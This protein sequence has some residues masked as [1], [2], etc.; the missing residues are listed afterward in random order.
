MTELFAVRKFVA[1]YRAVAGLV[2]EETARRFGLLF[3]SEELE[4]ALS[5]G[6][7]EDDS[8]YIADSQDEG[9]GEARRRIREADASLEVLRARSVAE[10]L[11][12]HGLDFSRGEYL[13]VPQASGRAFLEGRDIF[14]LSVY[15]DSHWKVALQPAPGELE[16]EAERERLAEAEAEAEERVMARLSEAVM[17]EAGRL[18]ACEE[19]LARFDLARACAILV[20][21]LGLVRPCFAGRG[22]ALYSVRGGRHLPCERSCRALGSE[23]RPLDLGLE[24]N[25]AVIFGSNMGGKT[26]ALMSILYFQILAQLGLFVPAEAFETRPYRFIQ[27]I[28][29]LPASASPRRAEG[30]SGFGFEIRSLCEAWREACSGEAGGIEE[31]AATGIGRETGDALLVF[32]EF[33]RTTSSREAEALISAVLE[34][35]SEKPGLLCL[36][37]THFSGVARLPGVSYLRVPGLDRL[38]ARAAL[39]SDAAIPSDASLGERIRRING[40][41][42]HGLVE[43]SGDASHGSDALAIASLL[44]LDEAI[45]GRAGE[46]YAP[47][48]FLRSGEF[49]PAPGKS[50]LYKEE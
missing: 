41:M 36:F 12:R 47:S 16:L 39:D 1:N 29:E 25:A 28:G 24:R 45:V 43:D 7:R 23:Y 44:G 13:I 4:R 49:L 19:A 26:V 3:A 50:A 11:A 37:S 21:E 33:A 34:A 38:A 42:R 22:A 20:D 32:D 14:S 6:G 31:P 27:Y 48:G 5:P 10:A 18:C 46:F 40:L 9:L 30:L 15:D 8:F 17:S 2:D 35:F